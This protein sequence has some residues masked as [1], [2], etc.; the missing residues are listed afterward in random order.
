MPPTTR[1]TR[2]ALRA[3]IGGPGFARGA[4]V[5]LP[6]IESLDLLGDLGAAFCVLDLEHAALGAQTAFTQIAY[7]RAIGL[8]CLVRLPAVD[9]GAICRYLDAGAAGIQVSDVADAATAARLVSAGR[10]PPEGD[11]GVSPSQ[12]DGGYGALGLDAL[13]AGAAGRPVLVAQIERDLGVETLRAIA[14]SGVDVLFLGPADLSVRLPGGRTVAD[15]ARDLVAAT[16]DGLAALGEN[17]LG[18]PLTGA[19]ARY[20]TVANDVSSLAA[21]LRTAFGPTQL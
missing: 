4:F 3:A 2:S 14:A 18:E 5:K 13:V 9:P 7:A 17:A 8:P 10:Y 15:V 12:R 1:E 19:E 11:R 16:S 21:A 20:V 6:G